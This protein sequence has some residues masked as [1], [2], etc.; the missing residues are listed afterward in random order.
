MSKH[1]S[2]RGFT[3]LEVLVALAVF[4][5]AVTALIYGLGESTR[6]QAYLE[7][8]TLAHWVAMNQIAL[9][10]MQSKWPSVG[11]SNGSEEMTGTEWHW[12][13]TVEQ[14]SD[15]KLRRVEIEVRLEPDDDATLV[16]LSAFVTQEPIKL[17]TPENNGDRGGYHGQPNDEDND[18]GNNGGG[19]NGDP[20]SDDGGGK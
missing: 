16:R 20:P 17:S 10:R 8:R 6:A 18:G 19:N 3:L 7:Q 14:T 13:R 1:A 5:V 2:S 4:A 11:I 12:T 15:P 9:T